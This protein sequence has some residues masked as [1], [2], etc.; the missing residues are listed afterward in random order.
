MGCSIRSR[1][2]LNLDLPSMVWKQLIDVPLVKQ[3]L[4]NIDR[5][6]I[7]CLDNIVN[8]AKKHVTKENFNDYFQ[9]RFITY[10]SDS[11]EMELIT[12]GRERLVTFENREEYA[13]LVQQ[14]RLQES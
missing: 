3:D 11:K 12:G 4:D 1:N 8:I 7:Q 2:F 13:R 6:S 14:T 9:D 10:L 5:F